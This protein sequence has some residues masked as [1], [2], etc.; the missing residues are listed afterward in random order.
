MPWPMKNRRSYCIIRKVFLP[1][2]K[3]ILIL[4][5][6]VKSGEQWFGFLV[7][8]P[9]KGWASKERIEEYQII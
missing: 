3:L 5:I 8:D 2:R 6:L 1:D 7:P 4:R 9:E